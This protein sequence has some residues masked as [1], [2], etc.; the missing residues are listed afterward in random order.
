MRR[1]VLTAFWCATTSGL[2]V[3]LSLAMSGPDREMF[4]PGRTTDGHYQI[5]LACESC[6]T[7][8][9][10]VRDEACYDCHGEE[11]D[12]AG[13]SHPRKKFTDP[14]N[15]DR[16]A[17]LDARRCV[18]CHT[19]HRPEITE[20]MGVT[21]PGDY[22]YHCHEG[23]AEERPTHVGMAFDS[24]ASAGC[25]NFHDNRALYEDFLVE[26]GRV[27]VHTMTVAAPP[28][29][30]HVVWDAAG[31]RARGEPDVPAG[32]FA[33]PALTAA[34]AASAHAASGVGCVDC[35]GDEAAGRSAVLPAESCGDCHPLEAAGFSTG[36]HGMRPAAGLERMSPSE[37]RLAMQPDARS[38]ILDCGSCHDP[39]SVGVRRAAVD[40]CLACH[41]DGHSK[42]Y[43]NSPH[44]RLWQSEMVGDGKPGS[45][46][47]CASCHLPREARRVS[48][49]QQIVVQH[50]QNANLRPNEKMIREVCMRCH[51]L[52]FA[53]DSLA[54]R[55][56]VRRNFA[57][58]PG[59]HVHSID[60]ALSRA[61]LP[62][63][64]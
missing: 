56:L 3:Y 49:D 50:N 58:P 32:L 23:I 37:A 64:R 25:H 63:D 36:R 61:G 60:M 39:H 16:V 22:C 35:H 1:F 30:A 26:H 14:R 57:G 10:G 15:A 43:Q 46:V 5:E 42:A 17:K 33:N 48:G 47:S 28:R 40:A 24:C 53:I 62:A 20:P 54:D 27:E 34:W 55:D 12:T 8:F 13:D 59:R 2:G 51:S 6:H 4:L 44:S 31:R 7:P 21:V 29:S 9:G 38:L 41:A 18:T 19:E 52:A 11:L 45:G